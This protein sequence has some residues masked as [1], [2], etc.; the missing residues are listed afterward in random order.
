MPQSSVSRSV[1]APR[2][3]GCR[4]PISARAD[5]QFVVRKAIHLPCSPGPAHEGRWMALGGGDSPPA[6][7]IHF[8]VA[9]CLRAAIDPFET[10]D[11]SRWHYSHGERAS[12]R[13]CGRAQHHS[14]PFR[15]WLHRQWRR[16]QW[17]VLP[18]QFPPVP[19]RSLGS[20]LTLG[21]ALWPPSSGRC[22]RPA[23]RHLRCRRPP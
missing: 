22:D 11:N 3:I 7:W 5:A 20:R 13:P 19:P 15:V 12:E 16:Q 2:M 4:S 14:Q 21:S 18:P 6:F 23:D 8:A 9:R 17:P 10:E 1:M